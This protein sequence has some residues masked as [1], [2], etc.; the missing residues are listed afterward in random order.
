MFKNISVNDYNTFF[1]DNL[2]VFSSHTLPVLHE[3]ADEKLAEGC[4]A[5]S[6]ETSRF[7]TAAGY[8]YI[9]SLWLALHKAHKTTCQTCSQGQNLQGQ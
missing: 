7:P 4:Q 8:D 2:R 9:H 6:V 1:A 3:S 5:L